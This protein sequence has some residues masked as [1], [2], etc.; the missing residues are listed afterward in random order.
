MAKIITIANQKGGV[1]K[2]TTALC[3]G[4]ELKAKGYK[5]LYIDLD[6]QGNTSNVLKAD[7]TKKGSY[8]VLAER[9][10]ASEVIQVTNNND[11]VISASASLDKIDNL[12][13]QTE[14]QIGKEY[15][16]KESLEDVKN[17][18]DF[19][20]LDTAPHLDIITINALTSTDYLIIVSNADVFSLEGIKDL[21]SIIKS[22]KAYTNPNLE[23]GGI[24]I[25]KFNPRAILNRQLK[26]SLED[27][28]QAYN[29]KVYKTYIRDNIAVK[30][31]QT[32]KEPITEYAP[33]SNAHL[34]YLAFTE[35]VLKDS[36]K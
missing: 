13:N 20:I 7:V 6:K 19:I 18:F 28:A 11:Y 1:G 31:S 5:V 35:E 30:E 12:L 33:K 3:L 2:T 27:L 22:I 36:N 25:N 4:A 8:S 24:L 34:D 29:T 21:Q 16:L 26:E 9:L 32:L 14:N 23:I 10:K 17:D 15:R